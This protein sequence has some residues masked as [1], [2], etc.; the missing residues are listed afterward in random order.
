MQA[1]TVRFGIHHHHQYRKK[2]AFRPRRK[3]ASR[4]NTPALEEVSQLERRL[5]D[6]TEE[7]GQLRAVLEG[8][9]TRAELERDTPQVVK[10]G[11]DNFAMAT[12]L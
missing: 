7:A 4:Q 8:S 3:E 12:F 10:W 9:V 6:K 2:L 1:C 11:F 5:A